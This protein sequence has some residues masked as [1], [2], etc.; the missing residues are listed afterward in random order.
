MM[1]LAAILIP[2]VGGALVMVLPF[3]KRAHMAVY[4]E[5]VVVITSLLVG[6]IISEATTGRFPIV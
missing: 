2:I 4:L 5:I 3:K 1:L 6:L